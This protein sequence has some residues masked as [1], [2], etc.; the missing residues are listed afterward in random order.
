M[1][2]LILFFGALLGFAVVCFIHTATSGNNDLLSDKEIYIFTQA[3]CSHCWD[4]E[5]FLRDYY[6]DL[7]IQKKDIANTQ[8][9]RLFFACGAKFGLDK[10]KMGT[11]LFC[12]GDRYIMGW[13]RAERKQ[14][15]EYVKDYLS[16]E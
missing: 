6:P 7:K 10:S 3:T 15:E 16:Q 2:K 13:G 8:N 14:F 4:A 1:K 11:P 12:M 5:D 9:R